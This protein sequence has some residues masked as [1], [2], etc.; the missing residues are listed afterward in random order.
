MNSQFTL[1]DFQKSSGSTTIGG[2]FDARADDRKGHEGKVRVKFS[3]FG[4]DFD[5]RT[6]L[7]DKPVIM[8]GTVEQLN[9][10]LKAIGLEIFKTERGAFDIRNLPKEEEEDDEK[11]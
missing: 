3:G 7:K 6:F 4:K 5:G 8:L 11:K 2:F 10:D 1:T 9:A